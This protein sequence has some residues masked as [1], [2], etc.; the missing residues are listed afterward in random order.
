[1]VKP[2][3]SDGVSYMSLSGPRISEVRDEFVVRVG[4]FVHIEGHQGRG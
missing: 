4:R 3:Y 2:A 1:M